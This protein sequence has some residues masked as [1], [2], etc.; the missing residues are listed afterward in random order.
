MQDRRVVGRGRERSA[1]VRRS[2]LCI[3]LPGFRPGSIELVVPVNAY[4]KHTLAITHRYAGAKLTT[5]E[6]IAVTTVAQSLFDLALRLGP[7]RLERS[8]DEA[9]L[10]QA[11][12]QST[13]SPNG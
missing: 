5:V 13:S 12:R 6:G 7:W 11:S 9:I 2:R 3:E 8:M 1:A 4:C 10:A